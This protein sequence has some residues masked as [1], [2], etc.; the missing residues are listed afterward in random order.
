MVPALAIILLS[1]AAPSSMYVFAQRAA[2]PDWGARVRCVPVLI[3]LGT[4]LAVSNSRGVASAIFGPGAGEFVR[5][6]KQGVPAGGSARPREGSYQSPLSKVFWAELAMGGWALAALGAYLADGKLF[7]GPI[8]LLQAV[9]YFYVGGLSVVH[10]WGQ[11]S[12][13]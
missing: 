4:G 7:V 3:A 5:T 6:P 8:L 1:L 11:A 13:S 9:G 10:A 12:R 2:Y